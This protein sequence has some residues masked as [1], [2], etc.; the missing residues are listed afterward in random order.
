MNEKKEK[1]IQ[2]KGNGGVHPPVA[3]DDWS[4]N[5][6]RGTSRMPIRG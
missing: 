5:T 4:R 2:V 1:A 3:V 6:R